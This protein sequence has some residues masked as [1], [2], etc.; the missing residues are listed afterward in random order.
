MRDSKIELRLLITSV[1]LLGTCVAWLVPFYCIPRYG[2]HLVQEPSM[3][4]LLYEIG[5]FVAL[6][7]FS[8]SN[9]V[10]LFKEVKK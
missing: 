2:T 1:A 8:I 9:L 7:G 3:P 6:V 5:F 10:W 4:M